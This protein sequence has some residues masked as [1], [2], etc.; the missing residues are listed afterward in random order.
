MTEKR[1]VG[2]YRHFINTA[3]EDELRPGLS[4]KPEMYTL[5][6]YLEP[7]FYVVSIKVK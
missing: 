7:E 1:L 5:R 3:E 6:D 4:Q 2:K